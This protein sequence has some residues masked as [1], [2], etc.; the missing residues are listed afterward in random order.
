MSQVA[1]YLNFPG[2]AEEAFLT[3][4]DVFD[5]TIHSLTRFS[6]VPYGPPVTGDEATMVLNAQMTIFGHTVM[7]SDML[8]SLGHATR[9]GN[10]TT[11]SIEVESRAEADR[12]FGA[13]SV[14]ATE[15]QPMGDMPWGAYW[16]VCLDRFG[17]RWMVSFTPPW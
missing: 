10:N 9:I 12:I 15:L 7:C 14:D 4:A 13:L 6:D 5:T 3:Y 11:L 17:I 8:A 16:G 2:T 1:T